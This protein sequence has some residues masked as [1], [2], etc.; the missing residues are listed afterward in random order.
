MKNKRK[1]VKDDVVIWESVR[2][3]QDKTVEEVKQQ[4]PELIQTEGYVARVDEEYVYVR[5]MNKEIGVGDWTIIPTPIVRKVI[6]G[7]DRK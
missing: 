2:I 4:P 6:R 7:R 5:D 1:K 3:F